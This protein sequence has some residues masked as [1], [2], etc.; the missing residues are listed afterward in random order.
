MML[1]LPLLVVVVWL[2]LPP[3]SLH[4]C[5]LPA[6]TQ[7]HNLVLAVHIWPHLLL[8]QE[9]PLR[10]SDAIA[11]TRSLAFVTPAAGHIVALVPIILL[12]ST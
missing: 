9:L 4:P 8:Y 10:C 6:A 7:A 12:I 1:P 5:C 2:L 3:C 11:R